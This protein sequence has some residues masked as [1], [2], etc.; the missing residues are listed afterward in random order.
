MP[1]GWVSAGVAVLG[2]LNSSDAASSAG[3]TQAGSADA[4]AAV[5]RDMFNTVNAQNA[6]YRQA[7]G[8]ALSRLQEYLGL[9]SQGSGQTQLSRDQIYQNLLPKYTTQAT[10]NLPTDLDYL[11]KQNLTDEQRKVLDDVKSW[12]GGMPSG[13][14]QGQ[15]DTYLRNAGLQ[16]PSRTSSSVDTSGLNAAADAQFAGQ[17]PNGKPSDIY[18][19]LLKPFDARDLSQW[20]DP[21][22]KF[23]LEQGNL[24]ITNSAAARGGQMGGNTLKAISDYNQG[25][26][27]QEY[28][29][30][31]GRYNTNQN[32]IYNRLSNLAGMGQASASNQATGASTFAGQIGENITGAGNAL[33][34]GRIGSA[35]ALS[36]GLNNAASWFQ[37]AGG[38]N[39]FGGGASTNRD[40]SQPQWSTAP[41]PLFGIE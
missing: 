30:S 25:A 14:D 19:S 34:A 12:G 27:S 8:N 2:A 17:G 36:G 9:G 40:F 15:V 33:A 21:G 20:Q 39:I 16:P 23:R 41:S 7:G 13:W 6:P 29:N 18:G 1:A 10:S 24:G 22:Y 37:G 28:Q 38:G 4:A 5:Q 3:Q 31:F 26:A 11:S 32:N 35:N